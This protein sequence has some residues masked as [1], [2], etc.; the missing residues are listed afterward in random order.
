MRECFGIYSGGGFFCAERSHKLSLAVIFS[1][2]NRGVKVGQDS[3]AGPRPKTD[4]MLTLGV[5]L[6]TNSNVVQI[7]VSL[8]S[9]S[10][11]H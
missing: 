2:K 9:S 6:E 5:A 11:S 4:A 3:R 8:S 7:G 1:T 10:T